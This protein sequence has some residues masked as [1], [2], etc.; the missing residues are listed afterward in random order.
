VTEGSELVAAADVVV[1]VGDDVVAA[2]VVAEKM[3]RTI[4]SLLSLVSVE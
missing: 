1:D 2:A 3:D 4:D